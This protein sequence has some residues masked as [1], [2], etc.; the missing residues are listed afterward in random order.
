MDGS[1]K[2]P[3]YYELHKDERKAYQREY[4]AH[5]RERRAEYQRKQRAM[6]KRLAVEREAREARRRSVDAEWRGLNLPRAS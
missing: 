2:A 5:H 6:Q 1:D 4:Y 3:S